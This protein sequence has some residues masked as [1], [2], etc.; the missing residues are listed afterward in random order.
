MYIRERLN[1]E[2]AA[3]E[4]VYVHIVLYFPSSNTV[5]GTPPPPQMVYL[6]STDC[7]Y[8]LGLIN[9]TME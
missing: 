3:T 4:T 2:S 6:H 7:C 8:L 1:T 5:F 9:H